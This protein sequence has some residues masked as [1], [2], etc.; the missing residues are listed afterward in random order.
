MR[1]VNDNAALLEALLEAAVDAIM[2]TDMSGT[3][4]EANPAAHEI[5]GYDR[6]TLKG[7][8]INRLM[9]A[10]VSE[11]HNG[12]IAEYLRTGKARIIGTGR[13]LE[14]ARKDGTR[15]P[16]HIAVGH[17]RIE[18]QDIFVGI[19]HDLTI[20][21]QTEA[22]LERSQRME[23]M[24]QLTGGVAHDFNNLLT[25]ITGNLELLEMQDE[26][27]A[28]AAII[29]DALEAAELG[30]TLT[31][32]LM[33]FAR[34]GVLMPEELDV[35][36]VVEEMT[37]MLRG[38]LG[39]EI[40]FKTALPRDVWP[41]LADRTQLQTSL[42]NLVVNAKAAMKDGGNMRLEAGNVTVDDDYIAQEIDILPGQ[43]VRISVSDTGEGMTS[44]TRKRAFEP[45]FTT[46]P[47]NE[48]TGLGL[49]LIYGF[50]RQSGGHVTLY[51]EEGQGTTI[52]LYFPRLKGEGHVAGKVEQTRPRS[53]P[54]G[55]GGLVLVAE[56]DPA[57]RRLSTKRIRSLGYSTLE[58]SDA[59]EALEILAE[60]PKI[61]VLFT[62]IIMPGSMTGYELARKVRSQYPQIGVLLTT[63]Y[64]GDL[65]DGQGEPQSGFRLL[66]KPYRQEQLAR[67]L[68][69]F[70]E[71]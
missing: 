21:R 16:V 45:F 24:G 3:I 11:H 18:D 53:A 39:S 64:A 22:A 49:S 14:G 17:A 27:P 26:N 2:I 29:A 44:E 66:R 15:F 52:S 41:I 30:S 68:A 59:D 6:D 61:G 1:E 12:Y 37:K 7:L 71:S 4:L 25:I 69:A 46:K 8:S 5:F 50:V 20:R 33:A 10:G 54:A 48:G 32:Q 57:V 67:F 51:S 9:P 70:V 19:L 38:T 13:D 43:F 55:R 23:A 42:L 58:A 56:D 40:S 35:P 47:S 36:V 65:L 31:A 62:D 28:D 63:A 60:N 34:R